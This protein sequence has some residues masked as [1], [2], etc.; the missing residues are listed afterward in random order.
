MNNLDQDIVIKIQDLKLDTDFIKML[1]RPFNFYETGINLLILK[2][3]NIFSYNDIK[4][5]LVGL[6]FVH[7]VKYVIKRTRPYD[8]NKKIKKTINKRLDPY[9]FPSGHSFSAFLYALILYNKYKSPLFF[10]IP[11]LVG[12]SRMC[13]GVHYPSDVISGFAISYFFNCFYD[14]IK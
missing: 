8:V 2:L 12:F 1:S 4:K 14:S 9:S 3:L 10:I 5:L 7:Y 11:I 13:L 6:A